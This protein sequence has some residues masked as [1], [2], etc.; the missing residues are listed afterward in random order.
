PGPEGPAGSAGPQGS[1]G[2]MGPAG[3]TGATGPEGPVGPEGPAGPAAP[4]LFLSGA[5]TAELF[6][7][8]LSDTAILPLSG[9]VDTAETAVVPPGAA[10]VPTLGLGAAQVIPQN[11][12]LGAIHATVTPTSLVPAL[13]PV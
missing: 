2:P 3:P 6:D 4:P 13:E 1:A 10:P 9:V 12:T 5:N 11:L 8:L 7:G